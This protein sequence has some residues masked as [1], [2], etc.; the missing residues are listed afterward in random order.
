MKRLFLYKLFKA[1]KPWFNFCVLFTVLYLFFFLKKVDTVFTPYNGMFAFVKMKPYKTS[2]I[3]IKINNT[4]VPYSS[5]FWW[6]KDFFENSITLYSKY[7]L[8]GKHVALTEYLKQ[9]PFS[10]LQKDFLIKRLTPDSV[11]VQ[12]F[13]RWLLLYAEKN[14]PYNSTVEF[15]QYDF[16]FSNN[17]L[18]LADSISLFKI[19]VTNG[20][21]I[22]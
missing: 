12:S 19:K 5:N 9:K 2:T 16:N 7:I 13:P 18:H 15:I 17:K 6:K 14:I 11:G 10:I 22:Y 21:R 1:S 3:A 8:N 4:I 20:D